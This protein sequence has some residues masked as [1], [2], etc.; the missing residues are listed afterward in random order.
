MY[1]RT[2]FA[3]RESCLPGAK[4]MAWFGRNDTRSSIE[5]Q[6]RARREN[7]EITLRSLCGRGYHLRFG[8]RF[9]WLATCYPLVENPVS[10]R[11]SR[12]P[13]K[14]PKDPAARHSTQG[15]KKDDRHRDI[16]TATEHQRF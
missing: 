7:F 3:N 11:Q 8:G 13:N 2:I 5:R 16:D 14:H 4:D 9:F 10:E 6:T 15:P 12:R 1:L